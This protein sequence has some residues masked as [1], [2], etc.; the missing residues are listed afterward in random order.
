MSCKYCIPSILEDGSV[1][2]EELDFGDGTAK[3]SYREGKDGPEFELSIGRD[4]NGSSVD[5]YPNGQFRYC[6][7]CGDEYSVEPFKRMF[8]LNHEQIKTLLE[9]MRVLVDRHENFE[10]ELAIYRELG[11]EEKP[12]FDILKKGE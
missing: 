11:G 1:R 3:V 7:F 8:N 5:I 2:S 9:T 10:R 4:W 12:W 6:P